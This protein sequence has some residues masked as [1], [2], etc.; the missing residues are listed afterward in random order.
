MSHCQFLSGSDGRHGHGPEWCTTSQRIPCRV[1]VGGRFDRPARPALGRSLGPPPPF[2]AGVITPMRAVCS[3]E[4]PGNQGSRPPA[5]VVV[6]ANRKEWGPSG[7]N[8][9]SPAQQAGV[10]P[11]ESRKVGRMDV[12]DGVSCEP[13][14]ETVSL[15]SA[16]ASGVRT[17][18]H[19]GGG[20][21]QDPDTRP[22][23]PSSGPR[24][25]RSGPVDADRALRHE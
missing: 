21:T 10:R 1:K 2:G 8:M 11:Y 14:R 4:K 19:T 13:Q 20:T 16:C 3:G 6:G 18:L 12:H 24:P 23:S 17:P 5:G 7:R 15:G 22:H 9:A 25:N